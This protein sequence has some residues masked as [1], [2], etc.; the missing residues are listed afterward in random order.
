V[1]KALKIYQYIGNQAM[2][3]LV[4]NAKNTIIGFRNLLG[5]TCVS[6]DVSVLNATHAS[7]KDTARHPV[8]KQSRH[9]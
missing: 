1:F 7:E 3:Q 8:T 5:Q 6:I 4:K 9:R 2:P